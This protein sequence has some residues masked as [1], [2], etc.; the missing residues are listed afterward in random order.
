MAAG[1]EKFSTSAVISM[2][3]GIFTSPSR[4]LSLIPRLFFKPGSAYP[5]TTLDESLT[6]ALPFVTSIFSKPSPSTSPVIAANGT[7]TVCFSPFTVSVY[8]V[9][10]V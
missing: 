6:S 1:I 10:F 9:V 4:S 2:Y 7:E 5:S 3:S 8:D